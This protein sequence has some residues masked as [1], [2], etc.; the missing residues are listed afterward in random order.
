LVEKIVF[1]KKQRTRD[2]LIGSL[3]KAIDHPKYASG[4]SNFLEFLQKI[5]PSKN[6]IKKKTASNLY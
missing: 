2:S 5:D 3:L 6:E 1:D 4:S